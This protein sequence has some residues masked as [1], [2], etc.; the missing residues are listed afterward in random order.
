M[1]GVAVTETWVV[2]KRGDTPTPVDLLVVAHLELGGYRIKKGNVGH[3]GNHHHND[4]TV[5][6][7]ERDAAHTA[8]LLAN[9]LHRR[10]VVVDADSLQGYVGHTFH[11]GASVVLRA[12]EPCEPCLRL[13]KLTGRTMPDLTALVHTG[14]H[15]EVVRVGAIMPGDKVKLVNERSINR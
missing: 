12:L 4:G 2:L 8:G 10:N 7:I 15:C 1:S 3:V 6:L 11:V 5:T 13:A 14:L 9:G